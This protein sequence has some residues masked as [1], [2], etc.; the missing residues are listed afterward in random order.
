MARGGVRKGAMRL[1]S[2]W[3]LCVSLWLA[4]CGGSQHPAE[5][6]KADDTEAKSDAKDA[7]SAAD[8]DSE[9]GS[10]ASKSEGSKSS[11]SSSDSK[12][13]AASSESSGPSVK[14][15]PKD[16][17]TAPDV[18]FMF[19]F[20]QSDMKEQAEKECDAQAKD[21]P[22]KHAACMDKAKKRIEIDGMRFVQEK[23]QWYWLTIRR[24][25]QTL[26]NLHKLPVEFT[27]EDEHSVVLKP[28][29]KDEG[30]DPR[31]APG[32]TTVDVPNEYE[33]VIKDP[34]LGKMVYEAKIGLTGK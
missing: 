16:M 1:K 10:A 28:I 9:S 4:A 30:K 7:K 2:S 23:G 17:L 34:S 25:G 21:D 27:K 33:I 12:A 3:F 5:E 14:R 11:D 26:I 13:G 8:A 29:G 15:T 24:K 20:N 22:K 19:S 6:P 31:H 18:I 32:E